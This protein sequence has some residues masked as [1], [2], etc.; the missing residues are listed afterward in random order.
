[1]QNLNKQKAKLEEQRDQSIERINKIRVKSND[2]S[3]KSFIETIKYI[4]QV[5]KAQN[6]LID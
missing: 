1:M 6:K 3:R 2:N 4:N 5:N